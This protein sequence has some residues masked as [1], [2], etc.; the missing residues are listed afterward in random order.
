[1][2]SLVE[3]VPMVLENKM[4]MRKVYDNNDDDDNDD[5]DNDDGQRIDKFWSE[6]LTWA[7][8]SGEQKT[9]IKVYSVSIIIQYFIQVF[10]NLN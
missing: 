4:K 2:P 6:K 8:G 1:M 7:F 5:D 10:Q 3:I 9:Q